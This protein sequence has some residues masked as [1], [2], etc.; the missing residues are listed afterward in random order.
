MGKVAFNFCGVFEVLGVQRP[1]FVKL[2]LKVK[3]CS[4][5]DDDEKANCK[6]DFQQVRVH[7]SNGCASGEIPL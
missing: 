2:I 1:K 6:M 4:D 3:H 7:F 5:E